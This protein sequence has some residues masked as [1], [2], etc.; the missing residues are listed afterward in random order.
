MILQLSAIKNVQNEKRSWM[1]SL[2]SLQVHQVHLNHLQCACLPGSSFPGTV[3]T[4]LTEMPVPVVSPYHVSKFF[5][6]PHSYKKLLLAR[7]LL[8]GKNKRS[9]LLLQGFLKCICSNF[10][11]FFLDTLLIFTVPPSISFEFSPI[12]ISFKAQLS[13]LSTAHHCSG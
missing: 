9:S 10:S 7:L 8:I 6:L 12:C 4:W 5:L 1:S 2:I 3:I 11:P 13:K